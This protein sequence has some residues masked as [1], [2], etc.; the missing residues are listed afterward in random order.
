VDEL[1]VIELPS[2]FAITLVYCWLFNHTGGSVLLTLIFHAAQGTITTGNLG[3]TG[4]D[5][6][7]IDLL[8]AGGAL[9]PGGRHSHLVR[10]P[11]GASRHG[12]RTPHRPERVQRLSCPAPCPIYDQRPGRAA[13]SAAAMHS[14][15]TRLILSSLHSTSVDPSPSPATGPSR[16]RGAAR[17]RESWPQPPSPRA[18][19]F[20]IGIQGPVHAH[21]ERGT[22]RG[23]ERALGRRGS[24]RPLSR[25]P[26][27]QRERSDRL[28]GIGGKTKAPKGRLSTR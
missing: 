22:G 10:P 19:M 14:W 13:P 24:R 26:I 5:L 12:R 15:R 27:A 17:R 6:A 2:T 7:R 8:A 1:A 20:L 4:Q 25:L 9:G 18:P 23:T 3:F 28:T 16:R 21:G 11:S